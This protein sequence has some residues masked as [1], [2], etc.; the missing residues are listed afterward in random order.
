MSRVIPN[1][2]VEEM[3]R[4]LFTAYILENMD[5]EEPLKKELYEMFA[6]KRTFSNK[7]WNDAAACGKINIIIWLY[8]NKKEGCTNEA[9]D[10]AAINGHIET[11]RWFYEVANLR[12]TQCGIDKTIING[13]FNIILYINSKGEKFSESNFRRAAM[14]GRLNIVILFHNRIGNN[15]IIK[16]NCYKLM[17]E[18]S[19]NGH[20][21]VVKFLHV[22]GYSCKTTAMDWAAMNGHLDVVMFLHDNRKEGCTKCAMD[23]AA[24]K[25]FLEVVK[26]LHENRNEGC[27]ERALNLAIIAG[28]L[29]V[30]KWLC[31][32]RKECNINRAIGIA[33]NFGYLDFSIWLDEFRCRREIENSNKSR[34]FESNDEEPCKKKTKF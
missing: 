11:V 19:A 8:N 5:S 27:T 3:S 17:N 24:A 21:E 34:N 33:S 28:H 31:R 1:K 12:C 13:H 18:A 16:A 26:W 6:N 30:A 22:N 15:E 25:G 14:Y 23:Y 32:N 2:E 20:F 10:Q 9:V 4:T 7:D 29:E